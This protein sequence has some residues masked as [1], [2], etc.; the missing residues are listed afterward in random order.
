MKKIFFNI[1]FLSLF[2]F[3]AF[4]SDAQNSIVKEF[5]F[6]NSAP[7][8][9]GVESELKI[10]AL[11]SLGKVADYDC[12]SSIFING[13]KVDI[14]FYEGVATLKFNFKEKSELILSCEDI[15]VSKEINPIP[16]WLSILPPLIA[17]LLAL[18]FKEVYTAIFLGIF[19]GT[20]IIA[21][22]SG[23][24]YIVSIGTAFF[25]VF[26]TY[27]VRALSDG[28][29]VSI[30]I[31]S[32]LIGATV[33]VISRNGGMQ[34]IINKLTNYANTP[35]S[36][37]FVAWLMGVLIFFDDYANT[38]IVGNTI[39]PVTDKLKISREKL[40]YIVDSTAAPVASIAFVTTW[41]GAELSYIQSAIT[42]ANLDVS[43]YS[44]FF[45]SLKYC[46]YPFLAL[47]FILMIIYLKRDFG[48][49]YKAEIRARTKGVSLPSNEKKIEHSLKEFESSVEKPK[50]FNAIIPVLVLVLGTII[51]L[52][53]TGWDTNVWNNSEIGFATKLSQ[54]IG[55]S[56]SYVSLIRASGLALVVA[57][58]MSVA[59]KILS[60][61]EAA[62]SILSGFKIMLTAI[63]ILCLAWALS[64]LISDL[65]TADFIIRIITTAEISPNVL[66]LLSFIVS[67]LVSFSTG[68]SWGTM[69]IMYPL[70]L[71]ATW[72][73]SVHSGLDYGQSLEVFAHVCA[74]VISGSVFGDHCSP[75]S[76][77]TILSSL[78]SSCNHIQ[79]VRTQA[80]YALITALISALFGTFLVESGLNIYITYLLM[81]ISTVLVI[82]FFGKPTETE[83]NK[84]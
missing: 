7:I 55:N 61:K 42:L 31:F 39:R 4:F 70:I 40:A 28:S 45:M 67:A 49:M 8:I 60:I 3:T 65:R 5:K 15:S 10:I 59:Q 53:Y 32:M 38:L 68:T 16:L 26:D 11:D 27:I 37:Q 73:L 24:G 83:I 34:G 84:T 14:F 33:N 22:Y 2:L 1:L 52:F 12:F 47:F 80:P 62:E 6:E 78:S 41:I 29:H 64:N 20:L 9:K 50:A 76:D 54:I 82:Y 13:Q 81:I 74:T 66:P 30:I 44:I 72:A 63:I 46:F 51:G 77:T 48:P 43:P 69:A 79:H 56:D 17:I 71:P 18:I 21:F 57:V 75:I 35:R 25:G 19:S 36:G 23:T 58:I